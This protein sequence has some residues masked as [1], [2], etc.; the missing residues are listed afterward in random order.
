MKDAPC[1]A[2]VAVF[3]HS[4]TDAARYAVAEQVGAVLARNG[5]A[6][7]NGGYGGVMEA[8]AKGAA[9]AGG[10][11]IGVTCRLWSSEPN[12]YIGRQIQTDDLHG[13]VATLLEMAAS[14]YVVLPGGTGTLAELA[15]A[16][17]MIN[18][19]LTPAKPLVCVGEFWR[20]VVESVRP[21]QGRAAEAVQFA[22][23]AEALAEFFPNRIGPDSE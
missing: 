22:D 18:K 20:P 14:G 23:D 7:V 2:G 5:Y 17:E 10:D 21:L 11:V 12:G 8:S 9:E 13:R 15:I 4:K 19:R 3:G 6:V 1:E 16:W